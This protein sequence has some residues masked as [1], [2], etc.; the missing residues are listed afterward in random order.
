MKISTNFSLL[1]ISAVL[2]T[3]VAC[4]PGGENK[5]STSS[6]IGPEVPV[7]T[8]DGK[9]SGLLSN[10][11]TDIMVFKG[12][13]FAA[14]PVGEF[15]WKAPQPVQAWE[16]VKEMHAYRNSCQRPGGRNANVE[17]MSEDC[18]FLYVWTPAK[19]S[20]EKLPVMVWI[21]GGGF[22]GGSGDLKRGT[23][24]A[25][26]GVV[27][28]S[29]NYRLGALGFFAHPL[30][31]E[32]S[33]H[34]VSGNYGILDMIA[35][36]KWVES[37]ITQFGG[38][39]GN[40][41]IFGESA[42]GAAVAILCASELANGLFHKS[43]AESPWITNDAIS[44]LRTPAF[45]RES[46]EST[47]VKLAEDLLGTSEVT[48]EELRSIEVKDLV[49]RAKDYRLP[50]AIDGYVMKD[51]PSDI[52]KEGLMENRPMMLGTNTDEGTM[53]AWG[54][55]KMSIEDFEKRIQE[56]YKEFGDEMI[57]IYAVN[58]KAE[59]YNAVCQ[60]INDSWFAQPT[61]WMARQSARVNPDTYLYHFARK[62]SAWPYWGA[63]H[64]AELE[65]V[66]AS[67]DA[68]NHTQAYLYLS[69]AM[70]SYWT[71]FAKSG[72]PNTAELTPWP[73]YDEASDVNILLD[74]VIT[75]ESNYLMENL[76]MIDEAMISS[77]WY[78]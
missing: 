32:E 13:P 77:A 15:R 26:R 27:L 45:T 25:E 30:L 48:L 35:A 59:V 74:S 14:P 53:F 20:N 3:S 18:L 56:N 70:V 36:L 62:S 10:D 50:S 71:Q 73:K 54:A 19:E 65:Y 33:E 11:S 7:Q 43:I 63:S 39:P 21:H 42:G 51:H 41:S 55:D 17:G 24:L 22:T 47:G 34:G 5:K 46:V 40:V 61:R 52:F 37:N 49:E 64:A 16:G 12:I 69:D 66:F 68:A 31:S 4:N 29:I 72:D 28:V 76:D 78:D 9:I 67:R 75:V 8:K 57:G 1:L 6:P 60:S 2:M 44:P 23:A 58:E 38:D